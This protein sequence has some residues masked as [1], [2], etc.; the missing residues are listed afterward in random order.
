MAVEFR[1]KYTMHKI[2]TYRWQLELL[3]IIKGLRNWLSKFGSEWKVKKF[4][5]IGAVKKIMQN[6]FESVLSQS[7]LGNA[8]EICSAIK[9]DLMG[10]VLSSVKYNVKVE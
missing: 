9:N 1:P 8:M 2:W 3:L 6:G 5:G 10:W 7:S 4:F